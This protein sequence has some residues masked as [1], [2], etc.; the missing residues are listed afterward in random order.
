MP[1]RSIWGQFP[2]EDGELLANREDFGGDIGAA[3]E[4]DTRRHYRGQCK[5]QHG[6]FLPCGDAPANARYG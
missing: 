2:L 3:L 6:P 1:R 4:E 5:R